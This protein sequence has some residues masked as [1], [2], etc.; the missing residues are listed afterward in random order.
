[1][2][3]TPDAAARRARVADL[4]QN[5][6]HA[7]RYHFVAPEGVGRPFDPNGALYWRGRYHLFY[8]FQD[9]ALPHGGHCW[10]HASSA[11]LLHW[12]Y[13]PTALAPA[14]G[15]PETGIFSGCALVSKEGVPILVYHGVDVGTCLA[16]AEDDNLLGWRKSAHNPVIPIPRQGDP[17]WGVYNV[18]DPHVWLEGDT[19]YAILGGR[20]K[21][22]DQYDT[23]YLFTSDDLVHWRYERP[24]YQP[25]PAWTQPEEDCACPDLFPLGDRHMLLCISHPYGARAY[26]G[27]WERRE[28]VNTYVP[29]EHLRMNWP[30]GPCFAPESLVDDGGRRIF[31][32]WALD[33]RA[34]EGLVTNELGVMT[35]P[36]V[37]SLDDAGGLRIDPPVELDSLRGE[38]QRIEGLSLD[39]DA[40]LVLPGIAGDVMELSI[41]AELA[42]G[43][44]L[45]VVVR[46]SAAEGTVI[47]VDAAA[48]TLAIDTTRSTLRG[49]IFQRHPIARGD[50][51]Q[52][53]VRVQVAPLALAPGEPLTLRIYLDRSMLEVFANRRQCVTQ[54]IYPTREDSVGVALFARGGSAVIR[55]VE[56]W[57]L[58]PVN[59]G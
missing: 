34:G 55:S 47:A 39:A 7:P 17:G 14:P 21:P 56:A 43:A 31:W 52:S 2:I 50:V 5:D 58:A 53:D 13:H 25:N 48:R 19:Y 24:F 22:H 15:D 35:L 10:G 27:R 11:D 16:T 33:Q 26:L 3:P 23:A 59:L 9:P 37:L 51:P 40:E 38:G 32:A 41:V 18:F 44:T 54:R 49:D 6:P 20:V 46:R 29:E 12:E 36:R 1:M 8:I 42:E 4:V 57:P 45:G 28:G 30:G